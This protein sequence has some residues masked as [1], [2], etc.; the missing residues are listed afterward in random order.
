M[1]RQDAEDGRTRSFEILPEDYMDEVFEHT[2]EN[3]TSLYLPRVPKQVKY[4]VLKYLQLDDKRLGS[5]DVEIVC[6]MAHTTCSVFFT[7][8]RRLANSQQHY[9]L[10]HQ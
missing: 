9:H 10:C 6:T 1:Q 7:N 3:P 8:A 5:H 4:K 2:N